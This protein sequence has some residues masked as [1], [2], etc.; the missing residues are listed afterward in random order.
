MTLNRNGIFSSIHSRYILPSPQRREPTLPE[1][2]EGVQTVNIRISRSAALALTVIW[3]ASIVLLGRHYPS[4]E[5][6]AAQSQEK[7]QKWEYCYVSSPFSFGTSGSLST[8]VYV[9]QGGERW[10]ADSDS[11]G[12]AALNKLGADGWEL[13][14]ASDDNTYSGPPANLPPTTRFVLKRPRI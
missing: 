1:F 11:T 6:M 13:V 8:K 2:L 10:L 12:I 14:S 9:S 4:V 5:V 3:L 7:H